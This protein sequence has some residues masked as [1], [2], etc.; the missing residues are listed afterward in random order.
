LFMYKSSLSHVL[1]FLY[2]FI[3]LSSIFLFIHHISS[4]YCHISPHVPIIW[5]F[6]HM[7]GMASWIIP[8]FLLNEAGS[9]RNS[10]NV[11]LTKTR[12]LLLNISSYT[13]GVENKKPALKK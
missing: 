13:S 7:L 9:Y 6:P 3:S 11:T 12:V 8:T 2:P 1:P 10:S 4:S 5:V